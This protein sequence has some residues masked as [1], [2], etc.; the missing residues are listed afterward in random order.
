MAPELDRCPEG[1][2]FAIYR[3]THK[4]LMREDATYPRR[5]SSYLTAVIC[6]TII[7]IAG[8]AVAVYL[9][10][11]QQEFQNQRIGDVLQAVA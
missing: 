9:V 7:P 6:L 5:F 8:W 3:A 11:R 1:E 4:R 10:F 2:R